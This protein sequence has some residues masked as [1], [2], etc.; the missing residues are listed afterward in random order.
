MA[1]LQV[2]TDQ[3]GRFRRTTTHLRNMREGQRR[4]WERIRAGQAM[5]NGNGH[6]HST[7]GQLKELN[8]RLKGLNELIME[9]EVTPLT[10]APGIESRFPIATY[11]RALREARN[12]V[13]QRDSVGRNNAQPFW[14]Q[15]PHGTNDLT[16]ELYRR[17]LR[18]L[19]AER[20][21]NRVVMRADA[22]DML[23]YAAFLVMTL[24]RQS[25]DV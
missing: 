20:A 18:I 24:D 22:I 10:P 8:G 1:A 2:S 5:T 7:N 15:F 25:T 16:F 6:A 3:R 11:D 4:R 13:V 12:I 9:A 21:K 23:N 14:D 19:G 17:I